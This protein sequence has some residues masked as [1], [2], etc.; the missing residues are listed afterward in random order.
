MQDVV[1]DFHCYFGSPHSPTHPLNDILVLWNLRGKIPSTS[2]FDNLHP[3]PPPNIIH[4]KL[5]FLLTAESTRPKSFIKSLNADNVF[6]SQRWDLDI[7]NQIFILLYPYVWNPFKNILMTF[8][9]Y[10]M[11]GVPPSQISQI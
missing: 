2:F 6:S 1:I 8:E 3:P 7:N 4:K 11:V 10:L 9:T 5:K